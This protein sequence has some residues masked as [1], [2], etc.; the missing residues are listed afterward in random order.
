MKGKSFAEIF[1]KA[2]ERETYLKASIILEFTEGLYGLMQDNNIT[3]KELAERLGTTPAYVTKVLRGDVNF[4]IDSI[5]KLAKAAGGSVQIHIGQEQ[6]RW[7]GV[8]RKKKAPIPDLSEY[9]KT[10]VKTYS[11]KE[12]D[13]GSIPVAA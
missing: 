4:T 10:Q 5:V 3:R 7:F 11:N 6:I 8:A 13:D 1:K 12:T 9:T 2:K